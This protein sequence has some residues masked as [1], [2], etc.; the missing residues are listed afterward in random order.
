MCVAST[1]P[2]EVCSDDISTKLRIS[3]LKNKVCV[4]DG[5]IHA[6]VVGT[7]VD[8]RPVYVSADANYEHVHFLQ[9]KTTAWLL[10][11]HD[12]L[13]HAKLHIL[14]RS[15]QVKADVTKCMTLLWVR[16]TRHQM[17]LNLLEYK[18]AR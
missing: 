15:A 14:L 16:L 10:S 7:K 6:Q 1:W 9:C 18:Q 11:I 2:Y 3:Y 4:M 8:E 17:I 13:D 5:I 12:R